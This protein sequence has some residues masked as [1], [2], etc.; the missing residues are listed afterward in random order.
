MLFVNYKDMTIGDLKHF[1]DFSSSPRSAGKKHPRKIKSSVR[2][3]VWEHNNKYTLVRKGNTNFNNE[4]AINES[5]K[6]G[7]MKEPMLYIF[8]HIDPNVPR[9]AETPVYEACFKC[10]TYYIKAQ[11]CHLKQA[12]GNSGRNDIERKD[13]I[14]DDGTAYWVDRYV[15]G[16]VKARESKRRYDEKNKKIKLKK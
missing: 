1:Y 11:K 12:Y 5:Y 9:N 16:R 7:Q 14:M 13:D 10:S 8:R 6:Q 4:I 2:C 3:V 15:D